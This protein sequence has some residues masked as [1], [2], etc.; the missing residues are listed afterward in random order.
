MD[1]VRFTQ[2][3]SNLDRFTKI[4]RKEIN[5]ILR[6]STRFDRKS[7]DAASSKFDMFTEIL[8]AKCQKN[9]IPEINDLCLLL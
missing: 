5:F 7:I 4:Y 8:F 9:V 2:N 1:P 3:S 6:K